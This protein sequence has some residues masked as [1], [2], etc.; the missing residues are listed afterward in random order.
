MDDVPLNAS[1][2]S[3]VQCVSSPICGCLHDIHP[4]CSMLDYLRLEDNV[5]STFFGDGLAL[6]PMIEAKIGDGRHHHLRVED[7]AK[8]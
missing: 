1:L 7:N 4:M 6:P 8:L 3:N 5:P 2:H